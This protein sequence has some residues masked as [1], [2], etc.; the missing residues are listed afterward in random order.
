MTEKT[1]RSRASTRLVSEKVGLL[2]TKGTLRMRG[3]CRCRGGL[4]P[5]Y[6][7]AAF[8]HPS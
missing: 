5:L 8:P 2:V 4:T 7:G 3:S 1:A 6:K